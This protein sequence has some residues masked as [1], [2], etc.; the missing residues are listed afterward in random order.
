MILVAPCWTDI[1][2]VSCA[3]TDLV[4]ANYPR[5]EYHC[6]S[7]RGTSQVQLQPNHGK[8]S[9]KLPRNGSTWR[10]SYCEPQRLIFLKL[11]I[12]LNLTRYCAILSRLTT[13]YRFL[14]AQ[15]RI[16]DPTKTIPYYEKWFNMKVIHQKVRKRAFFLT[17]FLITS[18][19]GPSAL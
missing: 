7:Y 8:H 6:S 13:A 11:I 4:H 9:P 17:S 3:A 2:L 1:R 12:C 16:K 5:D 15:L 19:W 18:W 14:L 10:S